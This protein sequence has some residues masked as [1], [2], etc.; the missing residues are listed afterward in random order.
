MQHT[1]INDFHF[2]RFLTEEQLMGSKC[3]KCEQLYVPPRSI[4]TSCHGTELEWIQLKGTGK[5][6]AFT[7]IYVAPPAMVSQGYD[8]NHPYCTGV[9][10]LDEKERVVARIEGIDPGKPE[11]IKVGMPVAVAFLHGVEG[12]AGGTCLAFKPACLKE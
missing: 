7:L 3:A 8:R 2:E 4:C 5:L 12:D 9:V 6:A 1:P 10:E 11:E